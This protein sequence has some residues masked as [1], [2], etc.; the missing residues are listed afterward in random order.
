MEKNLTL[1]LL[2]ILKFLSSILLVE[3]FF[4]NRVRNKII[5]ESNTTRINLV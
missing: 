1:S 2:T 5:E 3:K 4:T